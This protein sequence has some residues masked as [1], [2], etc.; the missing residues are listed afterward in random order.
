[1]KS[2]NYLFYP[3]TDKSYGFVR[4]LIS[5][6]IKFDVISPKGLGFVGK[7]IAYA[8]NSKEVGKIVKSYNDINFKDYDSIILSSHINKFM[9]N[10]LLKII[11]S[12]RNNNLDIIN[13]CCDKEYKELFH[14]NFIP[15]D[16]DY[17][18]GKLIKRTVDTIDKFKLPFY[19]PQKLIIFVGGIIDTIDNFYISLQMKLGLEKIGYKVEMITNEL[20]GQFFQCLNYP[21]EFMDNG[22]DP[23]MQIFGLNRFIQAIESKINP[24]ILIVQIPEGMIAYSKYYNNT[25][26]IYTFMI[27]Q[28][29]RP[30]YFLLNIS[31]EDI[32]EKYLNKLNEYFKVI[33]GKEVDVFNVINSSHQIENKLEMKLDKPMY[34]PYEEIIKLVSDY[35]DTD[36]KI[37]NLYE[38]VRI[39]NLVKDLIERFT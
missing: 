4:G 11:K 20:D 26:G 16:K 10:E 25:F 7:D 18:E 15:I 21:D 8:V 22:T 31:P 27:G 13:Y 33:V 32:N 39:D 5:S 24:D 37:E 34:L 9:K 12:S 28:S 30:D 38:Q 2:K 3:Y 36:L 6:D 17:E 35:N 14:K 19:N 23:I 1:M 29:I